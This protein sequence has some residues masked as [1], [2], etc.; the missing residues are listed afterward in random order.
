MRGGADNL[1]SLS[2]ELHKGIASAKIANG[3]NC[4]LKPA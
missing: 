3:S 4:D 1:S 2:C